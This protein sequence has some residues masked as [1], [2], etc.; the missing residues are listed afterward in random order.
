MQSSP[1]PQKLEWLVWTVLGLAVG[2]VLGAFAYA[3][4][5]QPR[6]TPPARS[7]PVL[8]TVTGFALTNQLGQPMTA[9]DL[10]GAPWLANIIFT[11]CPGPCLRMTTNLRALQKRLPRNSNLRIVSLTADP[12]F[13][14]PAVLQRYAE[15]FGAKPRRWQFL[16]GPQLSIYKLATHQ[17]L[18]SVA[19][20][21]DPTNAAPADLFIHS[22]KLVLLDERGRLRA[23]YDGEDTNAH[24]RILADLAALARE[25]G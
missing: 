12:A 10:R 6:A 5:G 7:L 3:R 2:L 9:D 17:L 25:G 22:T 14:T 16:T 19:E 4:L 18:L 23:I 20:N 15:R 8:G 13:D 21:P 11:R 1:P 24:P